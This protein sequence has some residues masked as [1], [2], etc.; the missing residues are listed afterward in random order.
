MMK[1]AATIIAMLLT[2]PIS[3]AMIDQVSRRIRLRHRMGA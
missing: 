3:Y 2:M 1:I